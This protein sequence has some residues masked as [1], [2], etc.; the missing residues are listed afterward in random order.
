MD[1]LKDLLAKRIVLTKW[2]PAASFFLIN[3]IGDFNLHID[4]PAESDE[5]LYG[6]KRQA[7]VDDERAR[8]IPDSSTA[9]AYFFLLEKF[10]SSVFGGKI[11]AVQIRMIK[12]QSSLGIEGLHRDCQR[13]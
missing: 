1:S 11:F 6:D 3:P 5:A 9:A 13:A 7:T 8:A 4:A 10:V 12:L 2:I